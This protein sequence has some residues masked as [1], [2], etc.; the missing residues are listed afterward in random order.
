M[1]H[2]PTCPTGAKM[3]LTSNSTFIAPWLPASAQNL[4]LTCNPTSEPVSVQVQL[5]DGSGPDP[6]IAVTLQS[7]MPTFYAVPGNWYPGIYTAL[8]VSVTVPSG[9]TT[10]LRRIQITQTTSKTV[11][12]LPA[13]VY[14]T[15]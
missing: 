3:P 9:A 15:D 6:S 4:V 11:Q 13:A 10:G 7:A 1:N 5:A 8:A 14:I 12:A 2:V